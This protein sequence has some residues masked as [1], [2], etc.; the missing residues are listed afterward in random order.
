MFVHFV[1]FSRDIA[2]IGL[3]QVVQVFEDT[4]K[5]LVPVVDLGH[6]LAKLR[7]FLVFFEMPLLLLID[8]LF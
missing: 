6:S 3:V 1:I 5:L 2:K 7:Y 4:L 8:Y